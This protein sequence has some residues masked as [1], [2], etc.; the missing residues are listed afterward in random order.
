MIEGQELL[1][2]D[3]GTRRERFASLSKEAL[4]R[5]VHTLCVFPILEGE[6]GRG[7][8]DGHDARGWEATTSAKAWAKQGWQAQH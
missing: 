1:L 6:G 8:A 7:A 4:Q 5:G 3:G 2:F